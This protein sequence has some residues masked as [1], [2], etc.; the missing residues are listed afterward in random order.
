MRFC[1]CA[2][3][4]P[5]SEKTIGGTGIAVGVAVTVGVGVGVAGAGVAVT[6]GAGVEVAGAEV[7]IGVAVGGT[8]LEQEDELLRL[9]RYT[10]SIARF[11]FISILVG[12]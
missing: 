2:L 5:R 10:A 8:D 6:V 1:T 9:L 3:V 4:Q 11:V 12:F 7:G